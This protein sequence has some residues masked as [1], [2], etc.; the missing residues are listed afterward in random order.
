M[1]V[2]KKT[3]QARVTLAHRGSRTKIRGLELF[4][5]FKPSFAVHRYLTCTIA[6]LIPNFE[7]TNFFHILSLLFLRFNHKSI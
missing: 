6:A 2:K 4:P 5:K 3:G 7:T 1:Q